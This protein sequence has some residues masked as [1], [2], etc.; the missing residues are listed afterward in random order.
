MPRVKDNTN[1][2]KPKKK[3]TEF[4]ETQIQSILFSL[5]WTI[6]FILKK[7]PF[8]MF[9]FREADFIFIHSG[10]CPLIFLE[11]SNPDDY[12]K[13]DFVWL[14]IEMLMKHGLINI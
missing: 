8:Y 6:N 2:K 10:V 7:I 4:L 3:K 1:K 12:A 5:H 13:G 14:S 11:Y 9:C